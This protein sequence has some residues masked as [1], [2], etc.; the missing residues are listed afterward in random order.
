[1]PEHG[2]RRNA[3]VKRTLLR[4]RITASTHQPEQTAAKS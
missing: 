2:V 1:M 4:E 3:L